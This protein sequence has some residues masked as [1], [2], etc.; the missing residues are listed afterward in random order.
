MIL[1]KNTTQLPKHI[2]TIDRIQILTADYKTI[3]CK[4]ITVHLEAEQVY[5]DLVIAVE[6]WAHWMGYIFFSRDVMNAKSRYEDAVR[7]AVNREL[8][9]HNHNITITR[10]HIKDIQL[11]L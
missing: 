8:K 2:I 6:W 1:K 5:P 9:K 10:L 3:Q 7:Q 11:N 4:T